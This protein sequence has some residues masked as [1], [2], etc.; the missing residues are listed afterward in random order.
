MW[1]W[2]RFRMVWDEEWVDYEIDLVET[3]V[4]FLDLRGLRVK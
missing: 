2:M 3:V 1:M 4:A